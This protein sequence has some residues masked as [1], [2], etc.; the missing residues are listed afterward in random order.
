MVATGMAALAAAQLE[1]TDECQR[2]LLKAMREGDVASEQRAE[3]ERIFAEIPAYIQKLQHLRSQMDE[4]SARTADMRTR[5][6]RLAAE[7]VG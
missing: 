5:S 3:V 7:K 6:A 1:K 2:N 4:L